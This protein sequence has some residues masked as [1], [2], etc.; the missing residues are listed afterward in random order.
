MRFC[1]WQT[2]VWVLI[3]APAGCRNEPARGPAPR[4]VSVLS[5]TESDPGRF[6]R[7]TGTVASWKTDQLGFEVEG[8]VRFVIE[9]ETD[10]AGRVHD[11]DGNRLTSGTPLARLD[12]TRY[13][14]AVESAKAQVAVAEKQREAAQIEYERVIPAETA[15]ATALRDLAQVEVERN[16]KLFAESAAP[17]RAVD[18]SESKLRQSEANLVQLDATKE[19]KASD[20]ASIEARIREL[21]EAQKAAERD[22]ADCE[23]YSSLAGQVA[24]VCLCQYEM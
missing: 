7:V 5:L 1:S 13:Q 23:L 18:L 24:E 20:V 10:I 8:R 9:P 17:E 14:L 22:L 3:L 12:P 2:V 19:A 16:K 15:A 11:E 4:P 21:E 6:E